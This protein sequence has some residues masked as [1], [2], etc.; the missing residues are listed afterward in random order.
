MSYK[1]TVC[2]ISKKVECR[3][4]DP[5]IIFR[6]T[7]F[8]TLINIDENFLI[9]FVFPKRHARLRP[10]VAGNMDVGCCNFACIHH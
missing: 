9:T 6:R 3:R 7:F 1:K 10:L 5:I 2:K 8:L 4:Y